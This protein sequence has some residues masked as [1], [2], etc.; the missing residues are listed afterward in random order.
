MKWTSLPRPRHDGRKA[1]A[2]LGTLTMA[3]S[4]LAVCAASSA[5]AAAGTTYYISTSGSDSNSGTS[6]SSPWRSLA[7]VDATTFQPGDRILFQDGDTWTG[8]LWPKGSGTS[9][10]SITIGSYGSGAEPAIAGA[11]TVPDAVKIWDQQY[12]TI[13]GLD[14]SNKS[15]SSASN[16]GDFR[17][18]HI[19]GDDAKTL[20]GFVVDGVNVHDVTGVDD[21]IGGSSANDKTGINF[22]MGWD[23]AKDTGGIVLNTTVPNIASPPSTPTV[24][25]NVTIEN[26]TIKNTSWGG[27]VTKQYEGDAPGAVDT[28]WARPTTA[29]SSAYAPFTDVTIEGNYITQAGTTYGSNGMLIADVLNGVIQN[30][31]VNQVGTSGIE[32]DYNHG[33]IAQHNEVTGTTVKAGGGDSNALDTDMGDVGVIAQYNYLHNNNVGYLTCLCNGNDRYGTAT[34]RYNVVADNTQQQVQLANTSSGSSTAV[35]NNTFYNSSAI[36]MIT[37]SG[38]TSFK[39]NIFYTNVAGAAMATASNITYSN[40]LYSGSSPTIPSTDTAAKTGNPKFADPTAGGTGTATGGPDLAGGRSWMIPANSPAVSAGTT[41]SGNG[42]LDY[43]GATVPTVPDIGAFQH[44]TSIPSP[45]FSD[46]FN[47][48]ATGALATGTDG[49]TVTSTG[50]AVK[51]V[52]TPSS[53]DKSVEL[54]RTQ[55]TGGTPGTNITRAFSGGLTGSFVVSADVMRNSS[56]SGTGYF[57][58]PY[59][60][61]S[62]GAPV[63]SVAFNNGE[64]EAYEGTA[65]TKLEAYTLGSWYHIELDVDTASQTFTLYVNGVEKIFGATFRASAPSIN[66][67]AFYANSSNYG[68]A[69]VNNVTVS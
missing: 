43:N 52:T 64:I 56:T 51:V 53:T 24:L 54:V 25:D 8:Q 28:G 31:F 30:N 48:L 41:I 23:R 21:W 50:N 9:T 39:N 40:N 46:T 26:S 18:I 27:I 36:N 22:A 58:L 69:Y 12:W 11:G 49:W 42:G 34:F 59:L 1:L 44:S 33:T 2:V 57:C 67:L 65:L 5:A 55:N 66:S 68:D 63:I 10:A 60:Y 38:A 37:G 45:V 4:G 20:S 19:G 16:L 47:A 17:G 7:K 32:L 62:S 61:N 3:T 15:G 35:Y 29:T 14:V 6:S 13:T